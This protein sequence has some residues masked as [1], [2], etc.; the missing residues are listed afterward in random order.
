MTG[1]LIIPYQRRVEIEC[2]DLPVPFGSKLAWLALETTDT[3][4]VA[5]VLGLR[6]ARPATWA[7]GIDA[8]HHA[9]FFITPPL[10][11]WTLV[12]STALITRD[13]VDASVKQ[14]LVGLSRQFGDAQYFCTNREVELHVWA[15]ARQGQF[16][17]GYA[18]LGEKRLAL[19]DEG[20][21]TKEERDLGF[22]FLNPE[23][24]SASPGPGR[25]AQQVPDEACVMQLASLWSIDPTTLDEYFKEPATGLL[26][27]VASGDSRD[28]LH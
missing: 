20:R 26:G 2:P 16:V 25:Q 23:S 10:A 5:A 11:D 17:R 15:R 18:W 14:L 3:Q 24:I 9:S 1:H 21:Q 13:R 12:A 27:N 22:Q 19:W 6:E 7:V 4:A 8:A 28:A